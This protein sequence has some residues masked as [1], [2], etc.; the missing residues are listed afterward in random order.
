MSPDQL[1]AYFP[2]LGKQPDDCDKHNRIL[3]SQDLRCHD[4]RKFNQFRRTTE[5]TVLARSE[6]TI[7]QADTSN[8]YCAYF[9]FT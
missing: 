6:V 2:C 5:Q 7:K 3:A 4:L 8:I 1:R 9:S